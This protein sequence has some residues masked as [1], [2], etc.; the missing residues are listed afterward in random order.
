MK[1]LSTWCIKPQ[2]LADNHVRAS[3]SVLR[4]GCSSMLCGETRC[5]SSPGTDL[6][7]LILSSK[8]SFKSLFAEIGSDLEKHS[9]VRAADI[10]LFRYWTVLIRTIL[11]AIIRTCFMQ[12]IC[13]F[14]WLVLYLGIRRWACQPFI[15][16][17]G[18]SIND[19]DC[20]ALFCWW[21][22]QYHS[23]DTGDE[24]SNIKHRSCSTLCNRN[25]HGNR[26][27]SRLLLL[28]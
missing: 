10:S 20:T 17:Y 1:R 2:E 27:W 5:C 24:V 26:Y 14:A 21:Q 16:C 22:C 18:N 3:T 15:K 13:K 7:A 12:L 19:H 9:S 8:G 11:W 6:W 4:Q 23:Q 28:L 25:G